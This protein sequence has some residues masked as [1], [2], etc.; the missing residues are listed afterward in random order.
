[1]IATIVMAHHRL[2]AGEQRGLVGVTM[3]LRVVH[4]HKP[5]QTRSLAHRRRRRM[6]IGVSVK[7]TDVDHG[8]L[9]GMVHQMMAG[10]VEE[11]LL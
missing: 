7:V 10:A 5:P 4:H 9:L 8:Y 11:A 2:T 6:E 3:Y 1:M